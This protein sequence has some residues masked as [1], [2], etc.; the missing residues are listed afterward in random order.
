[1]S[2]EAIPAETP[3]SEVAA[4]EPPGMA[5]EIAPEP[6]SP[7]PEAAG[8]SCSAAEAATPAVSTAP[9]LPPAASAEG[10]SGE[11]TGAGKSDSV[12]G[13]DHKE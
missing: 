3:T 1:V 10:F 12:K 13:D 6:P 8:E 7:P 5:C 4:A 11:S 9:A 2:G